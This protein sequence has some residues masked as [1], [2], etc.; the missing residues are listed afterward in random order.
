[1][2]EVQVIAIY[3]FCDDFLKARG[4]Q[5]WPNVKMNLAEIMLVYIVATRFFYGNIERA[6]KTLKDGCY[7]IKGLSKGQLNAR[8]HGIDPQM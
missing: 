6:Y 3:C 8:L 2:T 4:H 7:I 1:M 5:D